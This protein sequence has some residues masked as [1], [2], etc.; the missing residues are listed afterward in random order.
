MTGAARFLSRR[1]GI[2]RPAANDGAPNTTNEP[3][4]LSVL[5][6]FY[7]WERKMLNV[8]GCHWQLA[9]SADCC[10]RTGGQAARGTRLSNGLFNVFRSP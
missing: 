2:L 3:V 5:S 10:V 7:Y 9:A 6:P 8:V 4:P 1:A